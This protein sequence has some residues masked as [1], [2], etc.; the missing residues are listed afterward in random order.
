MKYTSYILSVIWIILLLSIILSYS[1]TTFRVFL[2][3]SKSKMMWV[4]NEEVI[5]K[6][7][8]DQIEVNSKILSSLDKLNEN[9]EKIDKKN[10]TI[11]EVQVNTWSEVL[12]LELSWA[13][14]TW[15][16]DNEES[17]SKIE[18]PW[19]LISKLMPQ[20]I[21]RKIDN[22]WFFWIKD[23][24]IIEKINYVTYEDSKKKIKVFVFWIKYEQLLAFMKKNNTFKI[25]ESDTF[26]GY[27]FYLNMIKKDDKIRFVTLFEWIAVWFETEKNSYE[28]VKK[29][30]LN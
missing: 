2:K 5:L 27:T 7:N 13:I 9:L 15:T 8:E 18:L 1:S 16:L 14:L 24:K 6:M 23:E 11:R 20:I 19:T 25:N 29:T 3:D 22:A 28:I 4:T 26:F 10:P 30:L 21:P 17:V 12:D